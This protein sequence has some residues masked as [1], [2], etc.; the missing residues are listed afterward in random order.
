MGMTLKLGQTTMRFE[1]CGRGKSDAG[2]TR[3]MARF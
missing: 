1:R 2:T 3:M